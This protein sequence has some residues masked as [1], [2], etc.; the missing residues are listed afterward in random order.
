[1][2]SKRRWKRNWFNLMLVTWDKSTSF[3]EYL[4]Q[5]VSIDHP[6]SKYQQLQQKCSTRL[7]ISR[8]VRVAVQCPRYKIFQIGARVHNLWCSQNKSGMIILM[9]NVLYACIM[10]FTLKLYHMGLQKNMPDIVYKHTCDLKR[11]SSLSPIT[12]YNL[13]T[14]P[15]LQISISIWRLTGFCLSGLLKQRAYVPAIY[16]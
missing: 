12:S 2:W 8:S 16:Y 9:Q 10:P 13:F 11:T 14:S 5:I 1:M 3:C 7:I 4:Y 6:P 15:F